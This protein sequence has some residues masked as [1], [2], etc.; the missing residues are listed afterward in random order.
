MLTETSNKYIPSISK[1][2]DVVFQPSGLFDKP[3]AAPVSPAPTSTS[4]AK[5]SP[6]TTSG[7]AVSGASA[8]APGN[9]QQEFDNLLGQIKEGVTQTEANLNAAHDAYAK[10]TQTSDSIKSSYPESF[11]LVEKK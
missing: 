1:H 2:G 7:A 10:T 3:A 11:T 6:A 9:P 8:P 4:P 5:L